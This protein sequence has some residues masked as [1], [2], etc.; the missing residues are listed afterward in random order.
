MVALLES[1]IVIETS[2]KS[3]KGAHGRIT[4]DDFW[5]QGNPIPTAHGIKLRRI[6]ASDRENYLALAKEYVLVPRFFEEE[7]FLEM[8]W[9]EHNDSRA[10]ILVITMDGE[11]AGYCGIK[12]VESSPW[13]IMIELKR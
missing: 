2:Q 4:I 5:K 3:E 8:L 1:I 12:N 11:Y 7:M 10:L 13:E 6:E 9:E